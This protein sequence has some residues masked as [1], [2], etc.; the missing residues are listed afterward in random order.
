MLDPHWQIS[1]EGDTMSQI[2]VEAVAETGMWHRF[3][4]DWD[5]IIFIVPHSDMHFKEKYADNVWQAIVDKNRY[6]LI[7]EIHFQIFIIHFII[8]E[9][10]F[11]Y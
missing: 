3:T 11:K 4:R 8:F 9:N 2:S 7:F 1:V 10:I 6:F 5:L